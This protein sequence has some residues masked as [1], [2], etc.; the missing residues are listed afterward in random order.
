MQSVNIEL[1]TAVDLYHSLVMY[2][3]EIR[4]NDNFNLYK[5]R[6]TE[7]SGEQNYAI[8]LKSL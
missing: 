2:H 6:A 1:S 7:V 8:D 3:E 5:S 4:K